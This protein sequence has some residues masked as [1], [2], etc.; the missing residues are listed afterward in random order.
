MVRKSQKKLL[1]I[2]CAIGLCF[3]LLLLFA[4]NPL[5]NNWTLRR[6]EQSIAISKHPLGTTHHHFVSEVGNLW[7]QGNQ[8]DFF[9]GE[10]RSYSGAKAKI[11]SFYANHTIW[12]PISH[13]NEP[14]KI[15]FADEISID[16]VSDAYE[17]SWLAGTNDWSLFPKGQK[18]YYIIYKYDG[19]IDPIFDIRG[20]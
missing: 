4:S 20:Y 2:S 12:N 5:R 1:T 3:I 14:L 16:A 8:I 18:G 19:G 6:L 17:V 7:G 11:R 13:K 10:V 9:A 15:V